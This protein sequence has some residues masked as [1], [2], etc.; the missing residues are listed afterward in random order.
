MRNKRLFIWSFVVFPLQCLF[1]QGTFDQRWRENAWVKQEEKS[2]EKFG[3]VWQ[4]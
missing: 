4:C 2:V 1:G 3:E